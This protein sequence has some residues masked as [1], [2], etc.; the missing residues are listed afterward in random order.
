[1][2]LFDIF[3]GRTHILKHC[4]LK[5]CQTL[6]RSIMP[7][8]HYDKKSHESSRIHNF[9]DSWN[10]V[11]IFGL[12]ETT[13]EPVRTQLRQRYEYSADSAEF[14]CNRT[15]LVRILNDLH[16]LLRVCCAKV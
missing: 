10:F 11:N 2:L 16:N 7:L 5:D 9:W 12:F 6:Q 15:N 1:M 4:Q 13:Y 8:S 14:G 3:V